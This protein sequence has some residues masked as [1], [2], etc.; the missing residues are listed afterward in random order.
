MQ[1]PKK[2]SNCIKFSRNPNNIDCDLCYES[3]CLDRFIKTDTSVSKNYRKAIFD[4]SVI[5]GRY[6]KNFPIAPYRSD[7]RTYINGTKYDL[8]NTVIRTFSQLMEHGL[9]TSVRKHGKK[10]VRDNFVEFLKTGRYHGFIAKPF[11]HKLFQRSWKSI[12]PELATFLN[13]NVEEHYA[14]DFVIGLGITVSVIVFTTTCYKIGVAADNVSR[15]L[16][17]LEEKVKQTSD[18]IANA[19][20]TIREVGSKGAQFFEWITNVIKKAK[21]AVTKLYSHVNAHFG[22]IVIG[23]CTALV[24]YKICKNFKIAPPLIWSYLT[25]NYNVTEIED[26]VVQEH[27]VAGIF[28]AMVALAACLAGFGNKVNIFHRVAY[29]LCGDFEKFCMPETIKAF[30]TKLSTALFDIDPFAKSPEHEE[31]YTL[32]NK[33]L[34][35]KLQPN[36]KS[37]LTSN[38]EFQKTFLS[39]SVAYLSYR[40]SM[41]SARGQDFLLKYKSEYALNVR[42]LET[43]VPIAK[44]ANLAR[45]IP[46][47]TVICLSGP[48]G[49]GKTTLI[50]F[51]TKYLYEREKEDGL[52][53]DE[54]DYNS[55]V[56]EGKA[57]AEKFMDGY[58]NQPVFRFKEFLQSAIPSENVNDCR[59]FLNYGDGGVIP[60]P[61][62]GVE[63]K[64]G[65]MFTSRYIIIDTNNNKDKVGWRNTGIEEPAALNARMT[66]NY[67]LEAKEED[68][69]DGKVK[70]VFNFYC[71]DWRKELNACYKLTEKG[72]T[73]GRRTNYSG[74]KTG[75][76]VQVSE[77][78]DLVYQHQKDTR[79]SMREQIS[80]FDF[81]KRDPVIK[82][83]LKDDKGKE[84]E[85]SLDVS[86]MDTSDV[87][88][89]Q[90]DSRD[91]LQNG[92]LNI[93]TI[94]PPMRVNEKH[95]PLAKFL[96]HMGSSFNFRPWENSTLLG[97]H[98]DSIF[99]YRCVDKVFDY[100]DQDTVLIPFD[101]PFKF[102]WYKPKQVIM[103]RNFD[104]LNIAYMDDDASSVIPHV[105]GKAIR[106]VYKNDFILTLVNNEDKSFGELFVECLQ[107]G[108]TLDIFFTRVISAIQ[109]GLGVVIF[110]NLVRIVCNSIASIVNSIKSMFGPVVQ[111][112]YD[113][114]AK[115]RPVNKPENVLQVS[116][117]KH[118][119]LSGLQKPLSRLR[120]F[121]VL[122]D[123]EVRHLGFCFMIDVSRGF[124]CKHYLYPGAVQYAIGAHG[125][126][127]VPWFSTL[128]GGIQFHLDRATEIVGFTIKQQISNI[129]R[130]KLL[131][132]KE[133]PRNQTM[134]RRSKIYV[135]NTFN[136]VESTPEIYNLHDQHTYTTEENFIRNKKTRSDVFVGPGTSSYA[137]SCCSPYQPSCGKYTGR[138]LALHFAG[139]NSSTLAGAIY[140]ELFPE[141]SEIDE[142]LQEHGIDF[143]DTNMPVYEPEGLTYIGT[144]KKY[145]SPYTKNKIVPSPL[146]TLME[147]PEVKTHVLP[148]E[149]YIENG[150]KVE[151]VYRYNRMLEVNPFSVPPSYIKDIE[152]NMQY[153]MEGFLP[154]NNKL[155]TPY[156]NWRDVIFDNPVQHDTTVGFRLAERGISYRSGDDPK[157][158]CYNAQTQ[159][160]HPWFE[161]YMDVYEQVHTRISHSTIGV[162]RIKNEPLPLTKT[163]GRWYVQGTFEDLLLM[164]KYFGSYFIYNVEN[165]NISSGQVGMNPYSMD[166]EHILRPMMKYSK[167][168]D[169][170]FSGLDR[171]INQ[172]FGKFFYVYVR[173]FYDKKWWPILRKLCWKVV[174]PV[175]I[176]GRHAFTSAG[177]NPSGTF[178]TTMF[179]QFSVYL[180]TSF[181]YTHATYLKTLERKQFC[182][183]NVLPTFGDDNMHASDDADF[184]LI[185]EILLKWF[186]LKL[187]PADK[188]NVFKISNPK[189]LNTG[190]ISFLSREPYKINY[191]GSEILFARLQKD[192]LDKM[193][194]WKRSDEPFHEI[195]PNIL[196]SFFTELC[197]Y[198][199]DEYEN[200]IKKFE[201]VIE[202]YNLSYVIPSYKRMWYFY[203]KHRHPETYF[204]MPVTAYSNLDVELTNNLTGFSCSPLVGQPF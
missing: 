191:Q 197:A 179:N 144:T 34:E 84:K 157:T 100:Q 39:R 129:T 160:I 28:S 199:P 79:H 6:S 59:A 136:I 152:E 13:F 10:H 104:G 117:V 75:S 81:S 130:M 20:S 166:W 3:L 70:R 103:S 137:G 23:L 108:I 51:L 203:L 72:S 85:D 74:K 43:N 24:V 154:K 38:A 5:K 89:E 101:H 47:P 115:A 15:K 190:N 91:K 122:A 184:S 17:T 69:P 155:L 27:A 174:G 19:S 65:I 94:K 41:R 49:G 105:S 159:T 195:L 35:Y 163:K 88:A 201:P 171:S 63:E 14:L 128:D 87:V 158:S 106:L 202:Y 68:T 53:P 183:H 177:M 30:I 95:P 196:N 60:L 7:V 119:S 2:I 121:Y 97:E 198:G 44:A 175:L 52:I 16:N 111:E 109:Y 22:E 86:E 167:Q 178:L 112:D 12:F 200:W 126:D 107:G 172:Q 156:T 61:M 176:I 162:V 139:G 189:V 143:V 185:K 193:L 127:K 90:G 21:E 76:I 36:F 151:P 161:K 192:S 135:G 114:V 145:H 180:S 56:Y 120:S 186:G 164:K 50:N 58:A 194:H 147:L 102:R 165:R 142:V 124:I 57:I 42:F 150:L 188:T 25:T 98:M 83:K 11:S 134:V 93:P 181:S 149:P 77:L 31:F 173:H 118:H 169:G 55:Y 110:I 4:Y 132:R 66:F 133:I 123:G 146:L 8:T 73:I 168:R 141:E 80:K 18:K 99:P 78:F 92:S 138:V 170:D 62:S 32:H 153:Y 82:S 26:D 204:S 9:F 1:I 33:I 148:T 96:K 40:E 46:Q 54:M 125:A 48:S 67:K 45:G 113:V 64:G 131:S 29:T 116:T 71:K 182:K 187:T 37:I 140:Q